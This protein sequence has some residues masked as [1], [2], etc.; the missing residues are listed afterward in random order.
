M[1]SSW[2][3]SSSSVSASHPTLRK[4]RSEEERKG[5]SEMRLEGSPGDRR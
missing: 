1:T 5:E 3:F 2:E 4:E